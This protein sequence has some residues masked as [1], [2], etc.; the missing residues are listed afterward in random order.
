M[1]FR[2]SGSA[3]PAGR[4]RHQ[5]FPPRQPAHHPSGVQTDSPSGQD[6]KRLQARQRCGGSN[7]GHRRPVPR[8]R[9]HHR[10]NRCGARGRADLPLPVR[11][12]RLRDT[13]RAALD[14]FI[15]GHRHPRGAG[16]ARKRQQVR[17]PL[18][19]GQSPQRGRLAGGHQRHTSHHGSCR[20]R[21]VFTRTCTDAHAGDG[22]RAVLGE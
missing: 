18:L 12:Y 20:T 2:P 13:V 10:G 9:T 11:V 16:K 1:G 15:D 21:H 8:K 22:L 17:Q 5:G 7:Q 4:L 3:R 6:R 14:Q 19:R